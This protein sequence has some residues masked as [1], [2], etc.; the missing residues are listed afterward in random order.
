MT[1][2]AKFL[3]RISSPCAKREALKVRYCTEPEVLSTS[4]AAAP[5]QH[6]LFHLNHPIRFVD[7]VAPVIG[8]TNFAKVV[9]ITVDDG[10]GACID[11]K[12]TDLPQEANEHIIST[13]V[14]NV[15]IYSRLGYFT[16]RV[17]GKPIEAGT[18]LR[19]KGK[20][21]SYW[22]TRQIDLKR[23][24]VVNN[25]S[26]ELEAWTAAA[27]F[28]KEVLAVPWILSE[29]EKRIADERFAREERAQRKAD[30]RAGRKQQHNAQRRAEYDE[31]C[32]RKRQ[33][34]EREMNAGAII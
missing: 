12:I 15:S 11:L 16:V 19:A 27:K 26:E 2:G 6:V 22:G 18:V 17:D 32:E 7:I 30:I 13:S 1:S 25:T 5:G 23:V 20:F 8:I 24:K 28:R 33:A 34:A 29:E 21:T 10:S 4:D 3:L 14:Q 31:K 9:I